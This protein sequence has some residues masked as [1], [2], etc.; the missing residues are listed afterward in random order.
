M[1]SKSIGKIEGVTAIGEELPWVSPSAIKI[2]GV[3]FEQNAENWFAF[4]PRAGESL[5][6][7]WIDD[8]RQNGVRIPVDVYRDGDHV[9][10]LDGRRRVMAARIVYDEQKNNNVPEDQRISVR[11]NIRRGD[12]IELFSFNVASENRKARSPIH[13]AKLMAH[14]KQYGADDRVL[15][16]MFGCTIQTVTNTLA[17]LDLSSDVQNAVEKGEL[18]AYQ[19]VKLGD[20]PREDQKQTLSDMVSSGA[21][22]GAAA[23]EVLAAAKRGEKV[24]SHAKGKKMRSR[25]FLSRWRDVLNKEEQWAEIVEFLDFVLGGPP[26]QSGGDEI[27]ETL[28]AAGLKM[29]NPKVEKP[30]KEYS[31]GKNLSPKKPK[32]AKEITAG[33]TTP[34]E[35]E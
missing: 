14:A 21:T 23:S 29:K 15:A 20:L 26:P 18:A 7:E 31:Q 35:F 34:V 25:D 30:K 13:K 27:I 17:L 6:D 19:A 4:C 5:E 32:K 33:E 9:V 16:K 22:K 3:D 2:V 8:I 12:P 1:S 10:M 11:V 28:M 24:K